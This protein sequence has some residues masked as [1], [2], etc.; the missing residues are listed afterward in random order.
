MI[1]FKTFLKILNKCKV[2]VIIYTVF[3]IFFSVF[4]MQ[5]SNNSIN[6]EAR[7]PDILLINKDSNN[8]IT[9]NL[10]NYLKDNCNL[11]DIK[12][13]EQA[14]NDAL[15]YRDVH[16]IIYIPKDYRDD[17]I[18]GKNPEIKVKSVNDYQSAYSEILLSNY[19][20][21]ANIYRQ[22]ISD[23]KQLVTQINETLD[24]QIEVKMTSKIDTSNLAKANFYYNFLNYCILAGCVYVICLVISSFKEPTVLKRTLIG[25]MNYQKHN[26]L[27]LLSNGLFA[28]SLWLFYV[29]LSFIIVGKVMFTIS[30]LLYI[31]NSFIFTL[32]ALTVAF[33]IANLKISKDAITGVINVIAL[34]TSFICG[35]F[36][37]MEF[38]PE[39]V[40]KIAHILPSYWY[41]KSNETIKTLQIFNLETIK[42]I[43]INMVI[44]I[45]FSVIFIEITNYITNR[46]QID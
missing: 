37:S 1:V 27:L 32:C 30:G 16:Y 42:P 19:L 11:I 26:R 39:F 20:K 24:N 8:L 2:P 12:N 21:V 29:L 41:I 46:K 36:V 7:K 35:S 38:L 10:V 15:F 4:N 34:G 45:L 23:E 43:L 31:I 33:L 6:F 17:F 18:N 13:N 3:L 9:N 5:T 14:Q 40:L 25:K 28:F 44:L 22:E